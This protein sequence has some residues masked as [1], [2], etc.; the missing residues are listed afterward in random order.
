[1][2]HGSYGLF[3]NHHIRFFTSLYSLEHVLISLQGRQIQDHPATALLPS[4]PAVHS[5]PPVD[6]NLR[7]RHRHKLHLPVNILPSLP[8][9]RNRPRLSMDH[10]RTQLQNPA[11]F[12][13]A[14]PLESRP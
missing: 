14:R 11:V 6:L 1:V 3:I 10:L 2:V 13:A 9:T 5:Y 7:P 4:S 8:Q 12:E